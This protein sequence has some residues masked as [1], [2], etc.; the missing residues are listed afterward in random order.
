MHNAF[1]PSF[2]ASVLLASVSLLS[3]A[4]EH[5]SFEVNTFTSPSSLSKYT[6]LASISWSDKLKNDM[7]S[8]H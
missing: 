1:A 6:I 3:R 2:S 5:L 7:A 4:S 8:L